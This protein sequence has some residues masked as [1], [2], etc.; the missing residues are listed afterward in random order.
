MMLSNQERTDRI[1][2]TSHVIL[3]D[4]STVYRVD[5]LHWVGPVL[6]VNVEGINYQDTELMTLEE[7][8]DCEMTLYQ[9]QKILNI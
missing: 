3:I 7:A 2:N 9:A 1:L 4:N 6:F 8:S 5:G